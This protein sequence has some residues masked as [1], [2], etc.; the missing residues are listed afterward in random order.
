[1]ST[2]VVH[3]II[4]NKPNISDPEGDTIL[5]DLVLKGNNSSVKKIRAGKILKFTVEASDKKKAEKIVEKICQ[6]LRI[7]NPL[8]SKVVIEAKTN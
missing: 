8:V 7:F 4:E 3:V 2:Y 6:E 5:N 1:M